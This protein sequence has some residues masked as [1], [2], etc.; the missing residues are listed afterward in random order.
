M[1]PIKHLRLV[2]VT[3]VAIALCAPPVASAHDH[4][5][6]AVSP[7]AGGGMTGGELLGQGWAVGPWTADDPANGHCV[8][9]APGVIS[10][11][12]ADGPATCTATPSTL[13]FVQFGS[14]CFN[15][16]VP[17][18]SG[19]PDDEAVQLACARTFDEEVAK[20][21]LV[22]DGRPVNT[23]TPRFELVSPQRSVVVPPNSFFDPSLGLE[24][25]DVV[26]F[27]AHGW[28]AVVHDLRPGVHTVRE[29][30]TFHGIP[31]VFDATAVI[32]VARDR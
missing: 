6:P 4:G 28:G 19:D 17:A 16:E 14:S 10:P 21:R 24:P 22:V 15:F 7:A 29:V 2:A 9:L 8:T 18:G 25:G 27:T 30:A 32:Y 3:T 31:D 23:K 11:R 12:P 13:F 20:V 1:Y 5:R 26:T